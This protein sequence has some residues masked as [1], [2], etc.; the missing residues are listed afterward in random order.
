[1][2]CHQWRH[3]SARN[4]PVYEHNIDTRFIIEC[5]VT[6]AT[7]DKGSIS[8]LLKTFGPISGFYTKNSPR[9]S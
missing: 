5:N 4:Y 8:G 2:G 1:M 9:N 6:S 7:V 3:A